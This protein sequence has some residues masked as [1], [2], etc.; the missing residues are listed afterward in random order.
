MVPKGVC[1]ARP[2]SFGQAFSFGFRPIEFMLPIS[3][4][5]REVQPIAA[6]GPPGGGAQKAAHPTAAHATGPT[7]IRI[8]TTTSAYGRGRRVPGKAA[9][10]NIQSAAAAAPVQG[11]RRIGA[12]RSGRE[13]GFRR[14]D[15]G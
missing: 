9:G 6:V 12:S 1:A 10:E 4:Q 5:R 2:Q 11:P 15:L 3:G 13:A 8:S 7:T 14:G